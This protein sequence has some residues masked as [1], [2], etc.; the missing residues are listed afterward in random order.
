MNEQEKDDM[1]GPLTT[2][3]ENEPTIE[4]DEPIDESPS[5]TLTRLK[6]ELLDDMANPVFLWN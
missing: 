6:D 2:E 4:D 1:F 5:E 3:D